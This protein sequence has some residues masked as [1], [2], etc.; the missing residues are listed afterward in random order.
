MTDADKIMHPQH[1]GTDP[2]DIQIRINPKSG[3]ESRII[4]V[5][6]FGVGGG[7]R[8]LSALVPTGSV[9]LSHHMHYVMKACMTSVS[10]GA[11]AVWQLIYYHILSVQLEASNNLNHRMKMT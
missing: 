6:N 8:S 10:I 7:L 5:S 11:T 2:M 4:F 9:S 1:F 3:F